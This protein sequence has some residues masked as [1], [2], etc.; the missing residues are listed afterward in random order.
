MHI[1][2]TTKSLQAEQSV[3]RS[4]ASN[5]TL[6]TTIPQ[7]WAQWILDSALSKR[8][9]VS[10]SQFTLQHQNAV[11]VAYMNNCMFIHTYS[12]QGN[13]T[14]RRGETCRKGKIGAE[15]EHGLEAK[16]MD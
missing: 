5:F 7:R 14:A 2:G 10:R 6:P 9:C 1:F 16:I 12:M 15:T 4:D 13:G 11:C 3:S 8:S